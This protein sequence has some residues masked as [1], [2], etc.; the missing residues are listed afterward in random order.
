MIY[1]FNKTLQHYSKQR[2]HNV[3]KLARNELLVLLI[4]RFLCAGYINTAKPL[5]EKNNMY[6]DIT[7]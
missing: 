6:S 7:V 1:S 4:D 2:K 3:Y 5:S